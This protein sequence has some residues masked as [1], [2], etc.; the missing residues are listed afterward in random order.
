MRL[1]HE[2][3]CAGLHART[4]LVLLPPAMARPED[5][6]EQ[7][8]VQA[9]RARGLNVDIVLA[10]IGY[11]QVMAQTVA[12]DIEQAILTPAARQGY[13]QIWL[14]GISLGAFNALHCAAAHADKLAGLMLIAPYPGTG[15]VLAE[16]RAAGSPADWAGLP[17]CSQHDERRWWHWLCRQPRTEDA[18]PAIWLGLSDQDRFRQGQ[19]ML[20]SL[21]ADRRILHTRGKHDWPAWQALWSGWLDQGPFADEAQ[22]IT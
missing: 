14:A 22:A 3:V 5:M 9:V 21:I 12:A 7:G 19:A 11:Q 1:I 6:I 8:M 13:R 18:M 2:P 20:A 17:D 4:L 10:E 15:D 16:I